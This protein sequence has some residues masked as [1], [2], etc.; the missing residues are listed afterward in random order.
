MDSLLKQYRYAVQMCEVAEMEAIEKFSCD[1]ERRKIRV[2]AM[3]TRTHS[4]SRM[5]RAST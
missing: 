5:G 3:R 2:P 4:A 1:V